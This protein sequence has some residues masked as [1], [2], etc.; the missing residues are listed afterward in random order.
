MIHGFEN[1][2]KRRKDLAQLTKDGKFREDLFYRLNVF[3]ITLPPLRERKGDIILLTQFFLKKYSKKKIQVSRETVNKLENYFWPGNVR[4]LENVLQR[5]LILC[6][7]KELLP[8][9]IILEEQGSPENFKG[10]LKDFEKIFKPPFGL[11]LILIA[12]KKEV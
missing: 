8:D 5:A 1:S 7:G 3:P 9:H 10:T 6:D 11:S 2:E 4:Q 12:E